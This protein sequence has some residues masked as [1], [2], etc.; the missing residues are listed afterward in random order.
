VATSRRKFRR[1]LA[2]RRDSASAS[3]GKKLAPR[4][5][6]DHFQ[7]VI[8][9]ESNKLLRNVGGPSFTRLASTF[10]PSCSDRRRRGESRRESDG[11]LC[12]RTIGLKIAS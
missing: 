9:P 10:G 12:S 1:P 2:A 11:Q 7:R 6:T 4:R 8:T 5:Q 3:R